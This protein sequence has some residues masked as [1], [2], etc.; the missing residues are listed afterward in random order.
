MK[1]IQFD[2]VLDQWHESNGGVAFWSLGQRKDIDIFVKNT[3]AEDT[4]QAIK[5][6]RLQNVAVGWLVIT[7]TRIVFFVQQ[8]MNHYDESQKIVWCVDNFQD[9]ISILP[10]EEYENEICIS[11][12]KAIFDLKLFSRE[13]LISDI[14]NIVRRK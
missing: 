14:K 2:S 8:N 11:N 13:R 5:L 1:I 6:F 9:N 12:E 3:Y 7:R 10:S 4:L